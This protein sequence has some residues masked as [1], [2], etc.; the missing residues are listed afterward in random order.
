MEQG[1]LIKEWD[2]EIDLLKSKEKIYQF[3]THQ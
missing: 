3:L 1:G 2:R